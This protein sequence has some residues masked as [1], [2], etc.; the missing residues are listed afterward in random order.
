MTDPSTPQPDEPGT[1][2][3]PLTP[4]VVSAILRDPDSPL[5]PSQIGVFCDTCSVTVKHDYMVSED[6][7]KDERLGVARKHLTDN[8]NWSCTEAGDFCPACKPRPKADT[9]PLFGPNR[10]RLG[11]EAQEWSVWV[12][13]MD[14]IHDADSLPAALELAN[15]LNATFAQLRLNSSKDDDPSFLLGAVVLHHGYAWTAETEHRLGNDCGQDDCTRC[16]APQPDLEPVSTSQ[17]AEAV[18]S[19]GLEPGPSFG[20]RLAGGP[21]EVGVH[22]AMNDQLTEDARTRL[23]K[24]L[25]AAVSSTVRRVLGRKPVGVT[26]RNAETKPTA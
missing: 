21:Y 10:Q 9:T 1:A 23:V 12:S 17:W 8:E 7:T 20:Y 2:P 15:E 16:G 25:Q 14:D 24:A 4:E 22:V 26:T 6:M 13:G 18:V 11:Y 19:T 3:A 5:Y